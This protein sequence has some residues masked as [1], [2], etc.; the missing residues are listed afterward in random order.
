MFRKPLVLKD[1]NVF[2]PNIVY[3]ESR[4]DIKPY[5]D[6]KVEEYRTEYAALYTDYELSKLVS[7]EIAWSNKGGFDDV[8]KVKVERYIDGAS[9]PIQT[10]TKNRYTSG[11]TADN[12]NK[13]Y[14]ANFGR[15]SVSVKFSGDDL[16]DSQ[17][18]IGVNT[19]TIKYSLD[20]STY[21]TINTTGILPSQNLK[22]EDILLAVDSGKF[23]TVIFSPKIEVLGQSNITRT[24]ANDD[25]YYF[26]PKQ[27]DPAQYS[28][29]SILYGE[30]GRPLYVVVGT[31][32]GGVRLKTDDNKY[33][34]VSA[35]GSIGRDG[36]LANAYEFKIIDGGND[37]IIL[38]TSE[39]VNNASVIDKVLVVEINQQNSVLR[40]V[41]FD[42]IDDEATYNSMYMSYGTEGVS[43]V[44]CRFSTPTAI[45][46]CADATVYPGIV[47][48]RGKKLT[49]VTINNEPL[50]DQ[51]CTTVIDNTSFDLM[52][53]GTN[54]NIVKTGDKTYV[55]RT[56]CDVGCEYVIDK[57]IAGP[58]CKSKQCWKAEA[59][60]LL[61]VGDGWATLPGFNAD[62]NQ[63]VCPGTNTRINCADTNQVGDEDEGLIGRCLDCTPKL[64]DSI[65]DRVTASSQK[66]RVINT[67]K[68]NTGDKCFST[69]T[70]KVTEWNQDAAKK[71]T[72]DPRCPP[73]CTSPIWKS[74]TTCDYN[75]KNTTWVD[76]STPRSGYPSCTNSSSPNGSSVSQGCTRCSSKSVEHKSSA[77]TA[78]EKA[79]C[80]NLKGCSGRLTSTTDRGGNE[81][82]TYH[83]SGGYGY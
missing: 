16:T 12:T 75:T 26:I 50:G 24:F 6:Y 35:E 30:L 60:K 17:S 39:T 33:V 3:E 38:G 49:Q 22:K 37:K 34:T 13:K 42:D 64:E 11:D 81:Y 73:S 15:E 2:G 8:K 79:A 53:H 27:G 72:S 55:V 41:D 74:T 83:C 5:I 54:E 44:L 78:D 31:D 7:F 63:K 51:R 48:K 68:V 57:A 25:G 18:A 46:G 43:K 56:N 32:S 40:F 66:Q 62:G 29:N 58:K 61:S 59:D 76:A 45:R 21:K 28:I 82:W 20:G 14:F 69:P 71:Y 1:E 47:N 4:M 10:I 80:D 9:Q 19:F 23:K 70:A 65:C 36:T 77:I 67:Y 52:D